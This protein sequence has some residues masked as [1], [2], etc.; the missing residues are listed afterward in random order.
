MKARVVVTAASGATA[1]SN[2][3]V[4]DHFP[5]NT[6]ISLFV[7]VVG[8]AV[9]RVEHTPYN[10]GLYGVSGAVWYPHETLGSA[11]VSANADGNYAFP[12]GATRV[13]CVSG[14][15]GATVTLDVIQAGS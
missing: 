15:S 5:C 3:I 9:Y 11:A 10:V 12:I 14:A 6:D 8:S 1:V 13:V 7:E 4:C 2:A